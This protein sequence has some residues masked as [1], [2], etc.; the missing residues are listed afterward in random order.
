MRS[1]L[2][3]LKITNRELRRLSGDGLD[4]VF[5]PLT[6]R[7]IIRA[8]AS[9]FFWTLL[10]WLLIVI[11]FT[12]NLPIQLGILLLILAI[13]FTLRLI[14]VILTINFSK[15]NKNFI[16]LLN[17]VDR[18]NEILKGIH[19]NDQI[20]EAGNPE[21]S[22]KN[23][24][25][26]IKALQLT[27]EDIIRALKTERILR[28]NQKFLNRNPELFTNNLTALAAL[29]VSDQASEHGRLLNEALQIAVSAQEEIR[30]LQNRH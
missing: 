15:K 11:C 6:K 10:A 8:L 29:Q 22:L 21:V 19:I 16:N 4:N 9:T 26:I 5:R 1:D 12:I 24:Q 17:D 18:Y 23:R 25:K 20:E 28:E 13:G 14:F 30:K 2:Q 27:R 7:N 3:G